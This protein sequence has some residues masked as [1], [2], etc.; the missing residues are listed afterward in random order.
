MNEQPQLPSCIDSLPASLVDIAEAV[1]LG[2]VQALVSKF[3]GIELRI[4]VN[5]GS[6]HPLIK[7]LGEVDG[8]ALCHYLAGQKIYVPH[9]RPP[10]S[11]LGDVMRLDREGKSV[12]EIARALH[13]SQRHVRRLL[14]GPQDPRQLS[15]F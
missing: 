15:L 7:E 10:R 2:I 14:N 4:P 8:H 12:I 11:S 13:L 3:G 5:P 1:G 6:D 9:A